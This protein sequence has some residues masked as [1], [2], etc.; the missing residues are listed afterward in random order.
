MHE[1]ASAKYAGTRPSVV[2]PSSSFVW[3][4]GGMV[5]ETRRGCAFGM[6][7]G[8]GRVPADGAERAAGVLGPSDVRSTRTSNYEDSE[9]RGTWESRGRMEVLRTS[10]RTR[11]CEVQAHLVRRYSVTCEPPRGVT[12]ARWSS[13]L[14]GRAQCSTAHVRHCKLCWLPP[15]S[16]APVKYLT[17]YPLTQGV[18]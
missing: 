5:E 4:G 10:T 14:A 3:M 16:A 15:M 12:V 18:G 17:K 13:A 8:W 6:G 9:W 11:R 7:K 1:Q 2:T